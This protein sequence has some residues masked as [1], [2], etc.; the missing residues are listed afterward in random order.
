MIEMANI[1]ANFLIQYNFKYQLTFLVLIN[2][3][4]EVDE[5]LSEKRITNYFEYY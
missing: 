1:C 5:I 4:G 3:N 2:K